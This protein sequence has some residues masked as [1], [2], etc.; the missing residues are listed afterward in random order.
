MKPPSP[1]RPVILVDELPHIEQPAEVLVRM[2][3]DLERLARDE[4]NR[5]DGVPVPVE[6]PARVRYGLD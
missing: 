6:H 1:P 2:W 3:Q 4:I 5:P